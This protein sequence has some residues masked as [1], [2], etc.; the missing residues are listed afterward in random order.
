MKGEKREKKMIFFAKIFFSQ[1]FTVVK[2]IYHR[3]F[4]SLIHVSIEHAQGGRF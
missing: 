4:L 2:A 1:F 3:L